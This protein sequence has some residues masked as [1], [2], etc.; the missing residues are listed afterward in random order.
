MLQRRLDTQWPEDE[1]LDRV[2]RSSRDGYL[3]TLPQLGPLLAGPPELPV[4][5]SCVVFLPVLLAIDSATAATDGIAADIKRVLSARMMR[6]FDREWFEDAFIYCLRA[7]I[8]LG[9][10]DMP[11]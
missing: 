10:Q 8:G 6:S 5:R 9:I 11:H 1:T 3:R 7:C 4:H 2:I